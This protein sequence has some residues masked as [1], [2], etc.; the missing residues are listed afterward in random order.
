MK[1]ETAMTAIQIDVPLLLPTADCRPLQVLLC[2]AQNDQVIWLANA[3]SPTR[4]RVARL[5]GGS[6]T[7][8]LQQIITN[9]PR[10]VVFDF[11]PGQAAHSAL[12][13]S[14]LLQQLPR[15]GCIAIGSDGTAETAMLALRSGMRDYIDTTRPADEARQAIQRVLEANERARLPAADAERG[16]KRGRVITLLGARA[17]LGTSTIAA[18]LGALSTPRRQLADAD[19]RSLLLDMGMP[20]GDLSL[21]M[22][23]QGSFHF[24]EAL[25]NLRRLDATLIQAAFSRHKNGASVLPLPRDVGEL[26]EMAQHDVA[27]LM[28]RL[29]QCF[30]LLIVDLGGFG[31]A[32]LI[33]TIATCSDELWWV[34]DQSVGALVSL[35]ELQ[36]TLAARKL[37]TGP[38]RLI[39]NRYDG[40]AG[41]AAEQ[42]ASRFGIPLLATLPDRSRPLLEASSRGVLLGE[43]H[44]RDAWVRALQP[45]LVQLDRNPLV[46]ATPTGWWQRLT[47]RMGRR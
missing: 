43:A 23:T 32:D 46:E 40:E 18:H 11:S 25:R 22:D 36:Q 41:L 39:V 30:D 8:L 38:S 34:T 5:D 12:L 15:V 1:A 19:D 13:A 9:S 45:L 4:V 27:G 35:A 16:N 2:T 26:R 47:A 7:D 28:R 29:R 17:G 3:L 20:F 31:H 37:E 33:A 24:V 10:L 14:Q 21:Y 6:E 44:P 42:I